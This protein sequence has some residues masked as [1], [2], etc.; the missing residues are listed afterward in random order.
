MSAS[1]R[2]STFRRGWQPGFPEDV[3]QA[4]VAQVGDALL[5]SQGAFE[6]ELLHVLGGEE[7]VKIRRIEGG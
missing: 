6:R 7:V 2:S 5:G 3:L 1:E 4:A